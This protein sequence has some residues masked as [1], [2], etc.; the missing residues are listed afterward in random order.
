MIW[1]VNKTKDKVK[2]NRDTENQLTVMNERRGVK[3]RDVPL[4][5]SNVTVYKV[6]YK[7][8]DP[9]TL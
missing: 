1:T 9:I 3:R 4:L 6:R 2:E 7:V 8:N 5:R